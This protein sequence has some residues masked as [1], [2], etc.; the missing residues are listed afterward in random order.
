MTK[1]KT[2]YKSLA[3]TVNVS[4]AV[5]RSV[6]KSLAATVNVSG[7]V[8]RGI[9]KA[10]VATVNVAGTVGRAISKA[11]AAVVNISSTVQRA[12]AKAALGGVQIVGTVGRVIHKQ[13][14]ATINVAGDVSDRH[15]TKALDAVVNVSGKA[16]RGAGKAL[17]ATVNV[18]GA[19]VRSAGKSVLAVVNVAGDVSERH[20]AKGI[21]AV[22]NASGSVGRGI[23]K[24]VTAIV[25]ISGTVVRGVYK[26]VGG[27]VQIAASVGRVIHK[28]LV[29]TVNT[30]ST[31]ARFAYD[32]AWEM[33]K[34]IR[35]IL[36][37]VQITYTD[38][39]FSAGVTAEAT[40]TGRFTYPAQTTDNVTEEEY[41]WFSLH[42]NLLDGT[43]HPLPSNQEYSVGWWNETVCSAAGV[44]LVQPV[45][46]IEHAAREISSLLVVGDDKLDEYPTWFVIRLYSEGDVLVDTIAEN[47]NA[48]VTWTH[49]AGGPW[50]DI[51][52]QT[53]TIVRWSRVSSVAKISQFYTMLEETYQSEDGDLVSVHVLEER[54]Y[55][56]P[57]I[58]QGN[59]S[60]N[61]LTVRLNNIDDIF[62][63]GNFNSS[64]HGLLLNN[65]A[66]K[67]WL[68]CDLHS[69]V[70]VWF[71][72]GT[73][74]SRDWNAPEGEVWAEVRGYDMLDR[75]KQT[76]FSVSEVYENI[77]LYDLAVIVMTDAGLTA[78]D[79]SIDATLDTAAYTIPYAWFGRMSHREALRRI[80]AACLGQVYCNRDG[81]IV[82]EVFV[83][84][85][86]QPY[87]FEFAES[88]FFDVDHPLEWSQMINNVQ[89]RANPLAAAALQDICVD[90]ESFAVPGSGTVTKTHFFD[91][92]PCVDVVDPLVF[93]QSDVH[94]SLDS[95]T[96]YSWGVSAT[97]SNSDVDDEN[98]TSVT[99][100]GK[101]LEVT[102]GKIVEAED[103]TSIASNGLQAL[104]E[105]ITS[106]FWQTETQSQ[107]VAD[108]LLASYKDPRRDVIMKARGNIAMLLGDR[109]V[110]PDYRDEVT[111]EYA[112]MRQDINWDGG[113]RVGVTC[114][115]IL[116][117]E[118]SYQKHLVATVNTVGETWA[119]RHDATG[120][121]NIEST[122]SRAISKSLVA[123][124]NMPG[125]I[126]GPTVNKSLVA[127]VNAGG[128]INAGRVYNKSL[129]AIVNADGSVPREWTFAIG[130]PAISSQIFHGEWTF[131]NVGK[132]ATH[133]GVIESVNLYMYAVGTGA[134]GYKVGT[135]YGSGTDY[136]CRDFVALAELSVGLNNV[137]G[138]SIHVEVGD[139]I[140]L[141]CPDEY[142]VV[143]SISGDTTGGDGILRLAGYHMEDGSQTY[144]LRWAAGFLS[145]QGISDLG[146]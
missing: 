140:G 82:L 69:G 32:M 28:H 106:A 56:Q 118:I 80:A 47:A 29:A 72:L 126:T 74:Y 138:L 36:A 87:D 35:Q 78:A 93:T 113:M 54:E 46:T 43:F 61:A 77:T 25:N 73:F 85:A 17:A 98:V 68:G 83:A 120:I 81:I 59:I 55:T 91:V 121:V 112:I 75:L 117:G 129:S 51:V 42:R 143:G 12:L 142:A 41:K 130:M 63:A 65:R 133:D 20:I 125:S 26:V 11:L 97:Y 146:S 76:E 79:W 1:L 144:T 119:G 67:A 60:S 114:Q 89:A 134:V 139:M 71:P 57:T 116:D 135:F 92:S 14:V 90:A 108:S 31:A 64:L 44:F 123:T 88:N 3:A 107:A 5:A 103:A 48:A 6:G 33:N 10:I 137:T 39:F 4:G 13:I 22:V 115:N 124:I 131:I 104:G 16:V 18:S 38:P 8:G 95:M 111:K 94:I 105:P 37:K 102:G 34:P 66:I 45:L 86:A 2:V 24:A 40:E 110:A 50:A 109:V 132:T 27:G 62:S 96:I 19:V 127:T 21:A 99:I 23:G 53:L 145:L 122:I 58:P 100:Q 70:R 101:P 136:T 128:A 9:G 84:A 7:T 141:Y 49:T 52:K 30:I 15:I